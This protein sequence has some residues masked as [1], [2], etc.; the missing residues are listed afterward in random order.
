MPKG[1]ASKLVPK[2]MGPYKIT[3]AIPSTSNYELELPHSPIEGKHNHMISVHQMKQ[4][5]ILT[6]LSATVGK[7]GT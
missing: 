5:G 1:R 3:K 6:K 4:S 2:Y 7:E